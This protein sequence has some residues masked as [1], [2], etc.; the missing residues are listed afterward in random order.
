MS[1][2]AP[3]AAPGRRGRRFVVDSQASQGQGG[4]AKQT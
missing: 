1:A 3:A 2:P 4:G